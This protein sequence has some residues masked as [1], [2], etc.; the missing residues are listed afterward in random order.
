MPGDGLPIAKDREAPLHILLAR[1]LP[2][3]LELLMKQR[4]LLFQHHHELLQR[5]AVLLRQ[6]RELVERQTAHELQ[7]HLFWVRLRQMASAEQRDE[8]E[9]SVISAGTSTLPE[10]SARLL[11]G[12]TRPQENSPE[13][14]WREPEMSYNML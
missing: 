12:D 13:T 3:K 5:Q 11:S 14:F 4:E 2:T 10:F 1:T 6:R 8:A 7:S 9:T